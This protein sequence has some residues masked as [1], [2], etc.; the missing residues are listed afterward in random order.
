RTDEHGAVRAAK[1]LLLST[2]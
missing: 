1:G 2:E